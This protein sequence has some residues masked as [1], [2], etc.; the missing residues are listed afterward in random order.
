MARKKSEFLKAAGKMWSIMQAITNAVLELGGGDDDLHRLLTDSKLVKQ[1]AELIM[2]GRQK[3]SDT[4][5]VVVDYGKTLTEMI[6]LGKYAW[7]NDDISD[8]HFPVQGVGQQEAEL[9]L[10]HLNKDATTKEALA[11]LDGLGLK[12]ASIEHLLAFGA[13]NPDVQ[14][15]FPIVALGSVWVDAF[16]NRSC[17]YLNFT[18]GE[19]K[20]F[21]YWFG[22]DGHWGACCRFLAVRK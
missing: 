20:L 6:K 22:G 14:R 18:D 10:V 15:E 2:F 7:V 16:G 4:Y 12:P 3:A 11:H 21:L 1:V 17:P 13:A 19:R 5:R 8:K 9:V